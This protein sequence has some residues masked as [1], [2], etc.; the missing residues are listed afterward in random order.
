[1]GMILVTGQPGHGKTAW[2]IDHC[3]NLKKEGREIYASGI[4]DFDYQRAGFHFL[5]N[6]EQWQDLPDGSVILLDEC[7]TVFPNRNPGAKVPEHVEA[8]ARHRHR[9]FDFVLIAQQGLQ[10]DPFLRGLYE[11]H[12]HVRQTSI[13]R[14]KTKLKRWNQ[15]QS[16]VN[17]ACNDVVD[18]MRPSYV[19]DFYTSTTKITTKRH[20]PMWMRWLLFGL[21]VLVVALFALKWYFVG[22]VAS[23]DSDKSIISAVN[24]GGDFEQPRGAA[25][26]RTFKTASDYAIAHLPRFPTMPWTAPIYDDRPPVSQPQLFCL[27]SLAGE[28]ASGNHSEAGC[29]CITEQNTRYDISTAE[30]RR[31]ALSGGIY[32]PYKQPVQGQ[33]VMPPVPTGA[34]PAALSAPTPVSVQATTTSTDKALD[35]ARYGAMRSGAAQPAITMS[36]TMSR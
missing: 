22:K 20:M 23:Y 4:K 18:W 11:Q 10:L 15:Y 30:C 9:G 26:P 17:G 12:I 7:Y 19:F 8:M 36:S 24:R 27:S 25:A 14:G 28:D 21:V 34:I 16:N 2:A 1:M 29:T 5:Q 13:I 33:P 35:Q 31:I 32:N 6:P 3:F